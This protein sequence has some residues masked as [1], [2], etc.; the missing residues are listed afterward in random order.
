MLSPWRLATARLIL[1]PVAA[2]DLR[3]ISSLKADPRAF[4]PM[5]GGVRSKLRSAEEL[6]ED[7]Q[8]WGAHGFGM[9]AVR[10]RAGNAFMGIAGLLD[11]EDGRGIAL[12]FALWPQ[13]RGIG[14]ATEAAGAA[15]VYAHQTA[16]L[17]EVVAVAREDNYASRMV[18]GAIGMT[19]V[20]RFM[21]DGALRLVYQSTRN[22]R[23]AD[24]A[25]P[26]TVANSPDLQAGVNSSP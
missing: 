12:R 14:L 4:A 13:A 25:A 9:W 11:R 17:A 20:D 26:E 18:I 5:L 6:A 10:A 7:I 1:T 21:R 23:S 24:R 16:G 2:A 15:L 22:G 19:E 3:D 8:F